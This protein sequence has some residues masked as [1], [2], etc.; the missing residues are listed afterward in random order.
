MTWRDASFLSNAARVS[1]ALTLVVDL[2]RLLGLVKAVAELSF[3]VVLSEMPVAGT[4]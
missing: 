4:S 2:L 3:A 1:F